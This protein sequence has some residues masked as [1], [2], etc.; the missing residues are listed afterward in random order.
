M[1]EITLYHNPR[2]SKSR[3]ALELLRERA[4]D[5]EI[6]EYLKTPPTVENLKSIHAMLGIDAHEMIRNKEDAYNESGLNSESTEAEIFDAITR[7]P[8][9]L[10]RPIVIHGNRAVIA[11]PPERVSDFF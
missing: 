7:F 2:C 11:R 5:I 10:E 3:K 4:L 8:K 9:L 1:S 6:V